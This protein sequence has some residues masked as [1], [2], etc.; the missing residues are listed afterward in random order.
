MYPDRIA[1]I[2]NYENTYYVSDAYFRT[3][4]WTSLNTRRAIQAAELAKMAADGLGGAASIGGGGGFSG[5]GSGG[6]T[7]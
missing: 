7:R 3:L 1:E 6:G 5:G 2:Q 4:Y